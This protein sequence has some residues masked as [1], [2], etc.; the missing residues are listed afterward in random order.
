MNLIHDEI[1]GKLGYRWSGAD[2][3]FF[4]YTPGD[5]RSRESARRKAIYQ[6][7]A[8]IQMNL[9]KRLKRIKQ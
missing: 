3:K 4:T 1:D 2:G 5:E 7:I 6:A 9:E 8:I